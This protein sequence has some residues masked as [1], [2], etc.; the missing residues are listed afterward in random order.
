MKY[1]DFVIR[2]GKFIGNF[3]GMYR[4]F[5]DPWEQSTR[6]T[7]SREKKIGLEILKNNNYKNVIELGCGLGHYTNQIFNITQN[8]VGIDIS[9]SAIQKASILYPNCKFITSDILNENLYKNLD[10]VMMVEITWYVL[11]KLSRFKEI[12]SK[13]KF[14]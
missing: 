1:Q 2:D 8:C 4:A 11:E 6:E 13:N 5:D 7:N 14:P 10:C 12:I 3:E 9:E